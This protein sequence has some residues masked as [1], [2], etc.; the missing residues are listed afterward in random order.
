MANSFLMRLRY[1][2]RSTLIRPIDFPKITWNI[3]YLNDDGSELEETPG[4]L[5]TRFA[6]EFQFSWVALN[7]QIWKDVHTLPYNFITPRWDSLILDAFAAKP[8]VGL[9]IV[10]ASTA[11]EVFIS[12]VLNE[13]AKKSTIPPEVWDWINKRDWWVKEPAVREQFDILLK[14]VGGFSLKDDPKLWEA[15]KN[16][17]DAKNSFVH[18]GE[19]IIGKKP[20][21]KE[22][23]TE[24]VA[25]ASQ[26]IA[27][28]KEK[29]PEELRWPEFKHKVNVETKFKLFGD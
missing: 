25:K 21:S 1:V 5:R 22:L 12:H 11:L 3:L 16:L 4:L 24:M 26:I 19:A 9:S 15:F 6:R 2:T 28:I 10:L 20:V 23:A 18:E 27:Y 17:R 8:D 29:L 7:P 14:A 13:L